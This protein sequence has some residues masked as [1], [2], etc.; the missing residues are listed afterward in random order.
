MIGD[1]ESQTFGAFHPVT[2]I[3]DPAVAVAARLCV[4]GQ[5]ADPVLRK[6]RKGHGSNHASQD[7]HLSD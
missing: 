4:L 3:A 6:A 1:I 2:K 5:R 7:C